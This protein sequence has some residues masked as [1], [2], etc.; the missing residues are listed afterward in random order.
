M[1]FFLFPSVKYE[2]TLEEFTNTI[3]CFLSNFTFP[4]NYKAQILFGSSHTEQ[5]SKLFIADDYRDI[6]KILW[7]LLHPDGFSHFGCFSEGF[8]YLH[9]LKIENI[10][11]ADFFSDL[12]LTKSDHPLRVLHSQLR[13]DKAQPGFVTL[14][15]FSTYHI[16][17]FRKEYVQESDSHLEFTK[18]EIPKKSEDPQ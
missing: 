3:D 6:S 9:I 1:H 14:K 16:L 15:G 12:I 10:S 8:V 2:P 17:E 4:D 7:D 11:D 5:L 18:L 13:L